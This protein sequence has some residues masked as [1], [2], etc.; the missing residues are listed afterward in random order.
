MA[1]VQTRRSRQ[2]EGG[3]GRGEHLTRLVKLHRGSGDSV[4]EEYP[5]N[6]WAEARQDDRI[7]ARVRASVLFAEGGG[8]D[9]G[10]AAEAMPALHARVRKF[11]SP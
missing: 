3:E 9:A 10:L 11:S 7:D 6:V 1:L 8:G 2:V 4:E 5:S